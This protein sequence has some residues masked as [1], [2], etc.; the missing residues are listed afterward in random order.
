M[1][2]I[3][4]NQGQNDEW[5]CIATAVATYMLREAK[6]F[7]L[8]LH[9]WIVCQDEVFRLCVNVRVMAA[10]TQCSLRIS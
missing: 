5:S 1:K 4:K 6:K 7:Y 3:L 10:Q 9:G 8:Y 2:D